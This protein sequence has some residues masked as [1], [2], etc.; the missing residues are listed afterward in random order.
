ML[1]LRTSYQSFHFFC[2][3]L[4]IRLHF[5]VRMWT[6]WLGA[7]THIFFLSDSPQTH[8]NFNFNSDSIQF[9]IFSKSQSC[10]IQIHFKLK[11]QSFQMQF[12]FRITFTSNSIL[13]QLSVKKLPIQNQLHFKFTVRP[14]SEP[15][16]WRMHSTFS[17][18]D[19]GLV[20]S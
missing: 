4:I 3:D 9:T 19:W 5:V 17:R 2:S 15:V 6:W 20:S 18:P 8:I 10:Q 16:G 1:W 7:Q 12:R 11:S 14:R 13:I